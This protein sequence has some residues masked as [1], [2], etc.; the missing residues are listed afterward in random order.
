MNEPLITAIIPVYNSEKD[1]RRCIDSVANQT[2]RNLEIIL[3]DDGSKDHSG[4]IC[5]EYAAKDERIKCIHQPNGGV[6]KARNT[7]L[8]NAHGEFIHFPDSDDYMEPDT[9]EYLMSLMLEHDCDAV[10]FE[11][12]VTYPESE[13]VHILPEQYYGSF[14]AEDVHRIVLT[15]EP[16]CWNKLY[17]RKLIEGLKFHE[18]I[19]RGEDSLFA[20]FALAKAE[21]VWFD[22]RALYHYVQSEQSA[23][24]GV[25][26]PSQLTAMKLYDAYKPLFQ[27]KY[28]KLQKRFLVYMS[29][30]L[31]TLYCNMKSDK[32]DYRSEQKNV[33]KV[34]RQHYHE[35][36]LAALPKKY[37]VKFSFFRMS[38]PIFAFYHRIVH[39]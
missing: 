39:G 11:Y 25:F 34:F 14:K 18:E 33:V 30:L 5:D 6:S 3:I 12:Y 31:I 7:G 10:N 32:K 2:Y 27:V 20:Q 23:C 37:R 38:P 22:S 16:F 35:M 4:A 13:T 8:E 15:D 29:H 21:K 17:K 24:R 1:L 9:Y 26:R 19:L 36:D 28:P